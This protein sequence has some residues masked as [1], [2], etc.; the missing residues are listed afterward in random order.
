MTMVVV[1]IIFVDKKINI[2]TYIIKQICN[3]DVFFYSS[4]IS[5]KYLGVIK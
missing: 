2:Y 3:A 4:A 1:H 5:E